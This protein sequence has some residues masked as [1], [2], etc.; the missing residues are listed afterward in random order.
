MTYDPPFLIFVRFLSHLGVSYNNLLVQPLSI[1]K[2]P[3]HNV[4][5]ELLVVPGI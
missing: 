4:L 2:V 3:P 5:I 1:R